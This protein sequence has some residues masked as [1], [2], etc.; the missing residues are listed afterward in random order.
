MRGVESRVSQ[1]Y[2]QRR[3]GGR[4]KKEESGGGMC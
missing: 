4:G 1:E 2:S 3:V